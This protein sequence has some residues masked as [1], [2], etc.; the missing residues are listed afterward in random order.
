MFAINKLPQF[1]HPVFTQPCFES[2][3][4]DGFFLVIESA[5]PNF[6][7]AA[8]RQFLEKNGGQNIVD[9]RDEG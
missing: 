3:T 2:V 8:V 9:V 4:T 1:Y 6:E 5:D 7:L